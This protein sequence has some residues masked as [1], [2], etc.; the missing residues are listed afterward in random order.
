MV[1]QQQLVDGWHQAGKRSRGLGA[2]WAFLPCRH[3]LNDPWPK[4]HASSPHPPPPPTQPADMLEG[5]RPALED[6]SAQLLDHFNTAKARLDAA[7]DA[8]DLVG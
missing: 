6:G 2:A 3:Q 8:A 5:V 1:L 7:G 4:Q